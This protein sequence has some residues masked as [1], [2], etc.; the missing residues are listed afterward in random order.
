MERDFVN[1]FRRLK[2]NAAIEGRQALEEEKEQKIRELDERFRGKPGYKF[3]DDAEETAAR[4]SDVLVNNYLMAEEHSR[5]EY[6]SHRKAQLAEDNRQTMEDS[7]D[8]HFSVGHMAAQG[9]RVSRTRRDNIVTSR[10]DKQAA[11]TEDARFDAFLG[12]ASQLSA[13]AC[14]LDTEASGD[15]EACVRRVTAQKVDE[16]FIHGISQALDS[17]QVGY[18]QAVLNHYK[19]GRKGVNISAKTT[20]ELQK[21]ILSAADRYI[22]QD[23]AAQA[24]KSFGWNPGRARKFF[25]AS[26]ATAGQR[27]AAMD[28]YQ[29]NHNYLLQ[30][31]ARWLDKKKK[32]TYHDIRQFQDKW[33]AG[34]LEGAQKDRAAIIGFLDK[35]HF[36]QEVD[37]RFRKMLTPGRTY[38]ERSD[39]R[40]YMRV[41]RQIEDGTMTQD[42]VWD[43]HEQGLLD[44][45]DAKD[46]SKQIVENIRGG[47]NTAFV[48]RGLR[49]LEDVEGADEEQ[50]ANLKPVL[51]AIYRNQQR[52]GI[53]GIDSEANVKEVAKRAWAQIRG[54]EGWSPGAV[55]DRWTRGDV[56]PGRRAD[57][58]R[59][60]LDQ[61]R[62]DH[63]D[64]FND[65][66]GQLRELRAAGGRVPP[67]SD[68]LYKKLF[69]DTI[70]DIHYDTFTPLS[71]SPSIRDQG[72]LRKRRLS[73]GP[74]GAPL[75]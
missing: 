22:P 56:D 7:V 24:S 64:E 75:Q 6:E 12:K 58:E 62:Q 48:T 15:Y 50:L 32:S 35:E 51:Q 4:V 9:A 5:A 3:L 49:H 61:L 57:L 68:P 69:I 70:L 71:E 52:K 47:D 1:K 19:K 46:F 28:T 59:K 54:R 31:E 11:E 66:F 30:Q 26:A 16:F 27:Q 74:S 65:F 60:S 40:T 39:L 72:R 8:A 44:D 14:S 36:P 73:R 18:A 10:F 33:A 13:E 20:G 25:A 2:G 17:R 43:L 67:S 42:S 45:E 34:D 55:W 29:R 37:A 41:E 23:L 53:A 63:P 38:A 21:M